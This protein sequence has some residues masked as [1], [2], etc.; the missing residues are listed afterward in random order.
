MAISAFIP[1]IWSARFASILD[2]NLVWASVCNREYEGDATKGNTVKVPKWGKTLTVTDYVQGTA[3]IDAEAADGSTVDLLLNKQKYF[4]FGVDDVH[5]VQAS[6]DL[7]TQ[8]INRAAFAMANQV[9]SDVQVEFTGT[10]AAGR[11]A[12]VA[13]AVTHEDFAKNLIGAITNTKRNMSK[14]NIPLSDRWLIAHPDTIFGIEAFLLANPATGVFVPA[15]A[16]ETL[17][18]GFVGT[19][20]GFRVLV[21]TKVPEVTVSSAKYHRLFAGQGVDAISHVNQI[22]N[23]E[24]LRSHNAFADVVRGLNVYGTKAINGTRLFYIQHLQS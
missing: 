21:T 7:M 10:Y 12:T 22:D 3:L 13:E 23:V 14:A 1:N 4:H 11:L 17:R 15:T 6:P 9:D 2:A 18:N 19:L 16:D 8:A 24:A 20:L 5:Q